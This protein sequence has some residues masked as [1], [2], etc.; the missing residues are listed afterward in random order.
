MKNLDVNNLL[1]LVTK[2]EK[3][4]PTEQKMWMSSSLSLDEI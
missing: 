2:R 3:K 1:K 4:N